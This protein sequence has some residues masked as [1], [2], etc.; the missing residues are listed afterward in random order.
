MRVEFLTAEIGSTTTVLSAFSCDAS[1]KMKF[2]GQGESYTTI[3]EN[4]VTVGIEKAMKALKINL[5]TERLEWDVLVASSSAAGGLRM[6]VHGLV[7]DMTVK[8]AREA[9]LG[10]GGVIKLV[11]AGKLAHRDL[12][13]IEEAT[14]KLILLAGGVDYGERET[15]IHNA[16]ILKNADPE[17]PIV[18]AGNV[19]AADEVCEIVSV[20][21]RD[22]HVVENVYPRIDELNVEPTRKI[23]RDVFSKNIVKGPGMEKIYSLVDKPVIPT[24]AA[25]MLAAEIFSDTKGDVLAVDI[26]GATTDVD[27]VTDGDPEIE[28]I[29]VSPEPRAKRTVEGDLGIYVN[30]R[31]VIEHI[32][33]SELEREFPDLESIVENLTPYPKNSLDEAFSVRLAKYCFESSIRRHAGSIKQFY[34]P[35]GRIEVAHGK[36]LTA[37]RS[38]VGTGGILSRSRFCSKIMEGIRTLSEKHE[39][40]LL[41]KAIV[42][43]YRDKHYI[44]GAIGLISTVDFSSAKDLLEN[45]FEELRNF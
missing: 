27:S 35:T 5:G 14:P 45:S 1:G 25:V 23:I 6:T 20:N 30:A 28:S 32:G 17:I 31:H 29:L 43:L 15:V 26:G 39:K 42:K 2:V 41:P 9:A 3:D 10:A 38:I 16:E 44:F 11:T 8:A 24:P 21:G 12:K 22:V 40:E 36:D 13:R 33:R 7:Y 4:D 18:Y 34:G 37:V 19:V